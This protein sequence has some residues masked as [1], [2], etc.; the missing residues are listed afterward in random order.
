KVYV[1]N[2]G[3]KEIIELTLDATKGK[4]ESDRVCAK[5]G[6][7]ESVDGIKVCPKGYIFFA[8]FAGNAVLVA[9]PANGKIVK[10]AQDPVGGTGAGGELDRCS[11]VCLRDGKVYAANID[12]P[13]GNKNDEPSTITVFSIKDIDFDELLK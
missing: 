11:E 13:Y 3:D 6:P 12:L 7:A 2:F 1:A 5:G 8:D 9:N 4:V 10:L